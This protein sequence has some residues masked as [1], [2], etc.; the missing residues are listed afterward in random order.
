MSNSFHFDE[1]FCKEEVLWDY[2][3]TEKSKK[4]WSVMLDITEEFGRVC[5]KYGLKYTAA[6]G[7]LL[8]A[9]RHKGFIPWDDDI[10]FYMPRPDYEKLKVIAPSEFKAPYFFQNGHTDT[11]IWSFSKLR[12][13][14]TTAIQFPNKEASF[15]QGIFIDIF[16]I[17]DFP[18]G[19]D[20]KN[21]VYLM[22]KDLWTIITKPILG[23]S[24][25]YQPDKCPY[26]FTLDHDIIVD[27]MKLSRPDQLT[28]FEDL[29]NSY[30]GTSPFCGNIMNAFRANNQIYRSEWIEDTI[31]VPF[32]NTEI[33]IS[34]HY[35]DFLKL[36]YGD[37]MTPHIGGS[38]HDG[39]FMDPENPYT[40]YING[41]LKYPDGYFTN[42]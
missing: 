42:Q 8:G 30:Y 24:A 29:C 12:R 7:T 28:Q 18:D 21:M 4:I 11:I 1:N 10:D 9:V 36:L 20:E 23:A 33:P 37:Y 34:A 27:L 38:C 26:N 5:K 13:S 31:M 6:Y 40:E 32:E 19:S 14:D 25:V 39:M 3:V 41:N 22:E 17:D 16:P 35:D 2:K 15:N